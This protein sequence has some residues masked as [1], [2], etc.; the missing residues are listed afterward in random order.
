MGFM[1][2]EF[3][4]FVDSVLPSVEPDLRDGAKNAILQFYRDGN[5]PNFLRNKELKDLSQGDILSNVPFSYFD[6]SGEQNVFVA[7]AMV[8]ST[9]CHIDQKDKIVLVPIF[10]IKDYTGD[11]VALKKN[12]I[13]D[14]MYIPDQLLSEKYISFS[15][16]C[17]YKKSLLFDG[18]SRGK[19]KRLTSLNQLGYYFFIIKLTIYFMRKEDTETYSD[20]GFKFS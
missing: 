16:I 9:S 6:A 7:D 17:T 13:F 1:L 12:T 3:I 20:R 14:F 4:D 10:P 8:I 11:K 18:I 5:K 19:I 15:V 2:K